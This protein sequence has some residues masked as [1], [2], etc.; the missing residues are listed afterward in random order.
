MEKTSDPKCRFS[1]FSPLTLPVLEISLRNATL[2]GGFKYWYEKHFGLTKVSN[3]TI[4]MWK[5]LLKKC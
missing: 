5:R 2:T 3:K 1:N 4:Q